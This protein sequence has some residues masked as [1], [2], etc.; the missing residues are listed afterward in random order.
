MAFLCRH[1]YMN[2]PVVVKALTG[3][4]LDQGVDRVF[5]EAMALRQMDHPAVIRIQDC[6]FADGSQKDRPY[7]VMDYFEGATLEEEAGRQALSQEACLAVARQVAEGLQAAHARGILHRDVKPA[8]VLVRKGPSGWQAKLIDFG[9]ALSRN[10]MDTGKVSSENAPGA[11]P[12]PARCTTRAQ[13]EQMGLTPGVAVGPHSDVYGFGKT[14]CYALFQTP[15]PTLRHWNSIAPRLADLLGQ[16]LERLPA[17]RPADFGQ[18]LTRLAALRP[19]EPAVAQLEEERRRRVEQE[20]RL[21]EAEARAEAE[22]RR[23]EEERQLREAAARAE[24]ERRRMEEQERRLRDATEKAEAERRR[25]EERQRQKPVEMEP[26]LEGVPVTP[27]RPPP[28]PPAPPPPLPGV[29]PAPASVGTID[30]FCPHCRNRITV[31]TAWA[32]KQTPC[33][34]CHRTF[35]I[36]A[37]RGQ[38]SGAKSCLGCL[39]L[40]VIGVAIWLTSTGKWSEVSNTV[41][42]W[43]G[44]SLGPPGTVL[45]SDSFSRSAIDSTELNGPGGTSI[46][47]AKYTYIIQGASIGLTSLH[48][49][50]NALVNNSS[51]Y[52]IVEI[53][54][55]S[56]RPANLGQDLNLSAEF[57]LSNTDQSRPE[58]GFFFRSQPIESSG[59]L[60]GASSTGYLV[61]MDGAGAVRVKS[62]YSGTVVASSDSMPNFDPTG[63]LPA[64]RAR[65]R[66]QLASAA[67]S[68]DGDVPPEREHDDRDIADDLGVR[69]VG[70]ALLRIGGA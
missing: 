60:I 63:V 18:V 64:R 9:L 55:S 34:I 1:Q 24:A 33:P 45:V 10:M 4:E 27:R 31:P 68:S 22:S 21:R 39:V 29:V 26:S 43:F 25:L 52:A 2:A 62:L 13:P 23:K 7:L 38:T 56:G 5:A 67:E 51:G 36:P 40:I 58:A 65:T 66:K 50:D 35:T 16:C 57:R 20:R 14:C 59:G 15:E 37:P 69:R 32:R 49:H 70:G 28:P 17:G 3:A 47:T 48:V 61:I 54:D 30:V 41:Q 53:G 19:D 12:S 8:N 46:G 42:G 11:R 44:G 6:G